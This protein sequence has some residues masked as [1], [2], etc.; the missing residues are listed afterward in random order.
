MA[1]LKTYNALIK[2][3][4]HKYVRKYFSKIWVFVLSWA[5]FFIRLQNIK[6]ILHN[7]ESLTHPKSLFDCLLI[8]ELD[9]MCSNQELIIFIGKRWSI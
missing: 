3:L 4:W 9:F 5:I 7:S 8:I 1:D 2:N 6:A